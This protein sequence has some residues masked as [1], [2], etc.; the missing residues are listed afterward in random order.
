MDVDG[1]DS[2]DQ[3]V[4]KLVRYA[5]ACEFQRLVIRRTGITEK[6]SGAVLSILLHTKD[7]SIGACITG[8]VQAY[9]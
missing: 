8:I 2:Q 6:G 3:A 9:L 5:L 1:A 4:K 7:S